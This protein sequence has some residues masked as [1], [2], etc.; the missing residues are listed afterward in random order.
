MKQM[1]W[2]NNFGSAKIILYVN[3]NDLNFENLD[4]QNIILGQNGAAFLTKSDWGYIIDPLDLPYSNLKLQELH[5]EGT[6]FCSFCPKPSPELYAK[7]LE[8]FKYIQGKT[9][10]E[11]AV[12]IYY[13]TETEDFVF[14]LPKQ[15]IS[16]TLVKYEFDEEYEANDRYVPYLQIH[17]HHGMAASF[18]GTDDQDEK[19]GLMRYFGVLGKI[20]SNSNIYNVDNSFRLWTGTRFVKVSVHDVFDIP[21]FGYTITDDVKTQLDHIISNSKVVK[22]ATKT[23]TAP[24]IPQKYLPKHIDSDESESIG[25]IIDD[26]LED[27]EFSMDDFIGMDWEITDSVHAQAL[28]AQELADREG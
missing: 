20:N 4:P 2:V 22:S 25:D 1:Q 19:R 18:S 12:N 3:E 10:E 15:V 11:L 5:M 6:E 28:K 16:S 24:Y 17:S 7:I 26:L 14:E 21:E 9:K 8:C 27:G 13:D 23:N